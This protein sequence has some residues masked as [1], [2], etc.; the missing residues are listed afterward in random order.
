MQSHLLQ[1]KDAEAKYAT[2]V[3]ELRKDKKRLET[4]I[5]QLKVSSF[6]IIIIS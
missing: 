4:D 2:E 1:L 6:M 3:A 5:D